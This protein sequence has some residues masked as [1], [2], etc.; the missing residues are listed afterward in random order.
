M[1]NKDE[2]PW[3]KANDVIILDYENKKITDQGRLLLVNECSSFNGTL[4]EIVRVRII[5]SET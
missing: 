4:F 1:T 5:K 3:Y 2:N